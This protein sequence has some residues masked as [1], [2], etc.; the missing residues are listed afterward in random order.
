MG[1]VPWKQEVDDYVALFR[2]ISYLLVTPTQYW[3]TT[4]KAEAVMESMYLHELDPT[5]TSRIV[6]Y[7]RIKCLEDIPLFNI[8]RE[9]IEASSR[10]MNRD[11]LCDALDPGRPGWYHYALMSGMCL[12]GQKF[13]RCSKTA[14][15]V[16]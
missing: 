15:A 5:D 11:E 10:W 9:F 13:S 2:Y 4:E 7:N 6:G 8:S 14:L 16:R 12:D 1:L 3:E